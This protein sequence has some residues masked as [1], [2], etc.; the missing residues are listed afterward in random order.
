MTG[1]GSATILHEPALEGR[2]VEDGGNTILLLLPTAIMIGLS[3]IG[4]NALAQHKGHSVGWAIALGILFGV[5]ALIVYLV[6]P[7]KTQPISP[8]IGGY[9]PPPPDPS[10]PPPL[11]P[12]PP[13]EP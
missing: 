12:P 1:P 3:T 11:P 5:I 7:R 2:C 9:N 6:L 13:A 8:T 4:W 10:T